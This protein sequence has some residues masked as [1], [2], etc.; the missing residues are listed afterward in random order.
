MEFVIG[1]CSRFARWHDGDGVGVR[2]VR[3]T[4]GAGA[5]RGA[6]ASTGAGPTSRRQVRGRP[7]RELHQAGK[8]GTIEPAARLFCRLGYYRGGFFCWRHRALN[9]DSLSAMSERPRGARRR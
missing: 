4:A 2:V 6:A 3:P 7:E 1:F 9:T 5:D 8:R